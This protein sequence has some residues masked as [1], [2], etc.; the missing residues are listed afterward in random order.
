MVAAPWRAF[1]TAPRWNG[2]PHHDRRSQGER[3]PLPVVE[4]QTWDHRHGQYRCGQYRGDHQALTQRP[5]L[6]V[7][8]GVLVTVAGAHLS[9]GRGGRGSGWSRQAGGVAGG[10]DRGDRR[11]DR[12]ALGQHDV[13]AL[14]RKVDRRRDPGHPVE[15]LLDP[16]R[17]RGTSHATDPQVDGLGDPAGRLVTH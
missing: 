14:G 4:L 5:D 13:G 10:L 15:L 2:P 7:L 1:C 16:G 8:G 3:E 6:A 17:A 9:I 11:F 12:C